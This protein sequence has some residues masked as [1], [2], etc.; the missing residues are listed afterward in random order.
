MVTSVRESWF[1]R[2]TRIVAVVGFGGAGIVCGIFAVSSLLRTNLS[3]LGLR[4]NEKQ[5]YGTLLNHPEW[6]LASVVAMALILG[7][8]FLVKRQ[9]RRH[10]R[11][12][13]GLSLGFV[14]LFQ[15]YWICVQLPLLENFNSDAF[16]LLTYARQLAGGDLSSFQTTSET[17]TEMPKGLQ[18]LLA[19]PY[20]SGLL[21]LDVVFVRLFPEGT[22][23]ALSVFAAILNVAALAL[24]LYTADLLAGRRWEASKTS[25]FVSCLAVL[26]SLCLPIYLYVTFPY[27]VSIGFSL[28]LMF[29]CCGALSVLQS[30]L[31]SS[32]LWGLASALLLVPMIWCKT[33]FVLA[34]LA[35]VLAVVIRCLVTRQWKA[36]ALPVILL[37]VYGL[38][39]PLPQRYM[40]S[41]IGHDLGEGIPRTAW[42]AIGTSDGYL[43]GNRGHGWWSRVAIEAQIETNNDYAEMS[44][45]FS[46][47]IRENVQTLLRDPAYG[48]SF[49]QGK[50]VSEW[51]DPTFGSL[52]ASNLTILDENPA[53]L[54]RSTF[55]NPASEGTPVGWITR[56]LLIPLM[57]GMQ[58]VVY[59]L[60]AV[61]LW[62]LARSARP[63]RGDS[64][65]VEEAF[66]L[67]LAAVFFLMGFVVYTLWE[68]KSQY[69]LPF[70]FMLTIL[71]AASTFLTH[72]RT[73][74]GTARHF[75]SEQ[76]R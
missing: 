67:S 70:F 44:A 31:S 57:D 62:K 30:S 45:R 6:I 61:T 32:V 76:T 49:M 47:K 66:P 21:L 19:Y 50:Y 26:C 53:D 8:L 3:H 58:T 17:F 35:L 29:L 69:V 27:A 14:A 74:H 71:A 13:V 5:T 38:T 51:D 15:T 40:E 25:S 41:Y 63:R 33:T 42:I 54:Q 43:F 7:L 65:F 22:V 1:Q 56:Y 46:E 12:I 73:S 2:V 4:P 52:Y 39:S 36:L 28:A 60:A 23:I 72:K 37:V 11:L 9:G 64:R 16:Q 18:Y 68:A 55:F 20:Q 10:G 34:L 59:A 48:L 75:S 24:V